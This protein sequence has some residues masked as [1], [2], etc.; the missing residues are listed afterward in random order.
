MRE[1]IVVQRLIVTG[2]GYDYDGDTLA[3]GSAGTGPGRPWQRLGIRAPE[4][5]PDADTD[6]DRWLDQQ[7]VDYQQTSNEPMEVVYEND[8]KWL[9]LAQLVEQMP[10]LNDI[11]Y[12]CDNQIPPCLLDLIHRKLSGCKLRMS[13]FRLRS[14]YAPFLDDHEYRLVTSPNLYS[15]QCVQKVR[16]GS[17]HGTESQVSTDACLHEIEA[18]VAAVSGLAPGVKQARLLCDGDFRDSQSQPDSFSLPREKIIRRVQESTKL[19]PGSVG[20]L[21]YLQLTDLT[22]DGSC[23]SQLLLGSS[24]NTDFSVLRALRLEMTIPTRALWD[25][26]LKYSFP[27]LTTFVLSMWPV[28]GQSHDGEPAVDSSAASPF[29]QKLVRQGLTVLQLDGWDYRSS[30]PTAILGPSLKVLRLTSQSRR[31]TSG[32]LLQK[33]VEQLA[34]LCPSIEELALPIWRSQGDANEV[35][36]Y[37]ALGRLGRLRRLSLLLM[38]WVPTP[39]LPLPPSY[40]EFESQ[41]LSCLAPY[42]VGHLRDAFIN[43]AMDEKLARSIFHTIGARDTSSRP[44]LQCL[45]LKVAGWQEFSGRDSMVLDKYFLHIG[46]SWLLNWDPRDTHQDELLAQELGT[47]ERLANAE[48]DDENFAEDHCELKPVY[49]SLWPHGSRD[50]GPQGETPERLLEPG[51]LEDGWRGDWYS[52]PLHSDHA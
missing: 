27:A 15:I 14:L 30:S 40:N 26:D 8:H 9:P 32:A 52:L 31:G 12:G 39:G 2:Y 21:Q 45:Q 34:E 41:E 50:E 46:L 6:L 11:L 25:L 35:A 1:E 42:R 20:S 28:K 7:D 48:M 29:V 24:R 23:L 3:V 37:T 4:R 16:L 51:V 5:A 19:A 17:H 49:R 43:A 13:T 22:G 47:D 10:A 18:A 44:S 36:M 33:E 38:V